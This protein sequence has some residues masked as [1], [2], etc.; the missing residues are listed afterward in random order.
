MLTLQDD[1]IPERLTKTN[2]LGA[3]DEL[4]INIVFVTLC[5]LHGLVSNVSHAKNLG[6]ASRPAGVAC[7]RILTEVYSMARMDMIG[8]TMR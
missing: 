5:K 8:R 7:P 3:A 6:W 4:Y 1:R 2:R